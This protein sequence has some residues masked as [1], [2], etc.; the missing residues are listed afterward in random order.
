MGCGG[1][2]SPENHSLFSSFVYFPSLKDLVRDKEKK[3]E[4]ERTEI[5]LLF[6]LPILSANK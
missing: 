4:R 1:I 6:P 3:K 5:P 2:N